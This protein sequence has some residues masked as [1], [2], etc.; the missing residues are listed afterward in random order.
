MGYVHKTKAG[1]YQVDY[2]DPTGRKKSKTFRTAKAASAFLAETEAAKN[3]GSY[4]DPHAGKLR[5]GEFAERWA[6]SQDL[7]ARA[8]E[9]TRSLLRTHVLPRWEAWPLMKIEHLA[10]QEWAKRLGRTLS[11]ATVRKAYGVMSR[12]M[13]AAVRSRLLAVNPCEGVRVTGESAGAATAITREV[14]LNKLLPATPTSHRALVAT[15]GGTGLRWGELA[16]LPWGSVDLDAATLR[17]RQVAVETSEEITIKPS[18]KT[19]AGVRTIPLPAFVVTELR[20]LLDDRPSPSPTELVFSTASGTAFRR[21]NF[22]RQVWRPTLVRAGLLGRVVERG[23][24]RFIACWPDAEGVE[25][26]VEFHTER[27]A[28]AHVAKN[29][30]GG[31][32]FHDLRHSYATWLVLDGLPVN[33][34]QRIMGHQKAT[35]TLNLYT[36]APT[37][38]DRRV[39]DTFGPAAEETPSLDQV[40]SDASNDKI[41]DD[42]PDQGNESGA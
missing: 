38:Y 23:E 21:S 28:I 15:A 40:D 34:V 8:G 14:F 24:H 25:W 17:V 20:R 33:V 10:V 4:V 27:E 30:A 22:R 29:A 7:G 37:D 12:I 5:F 18:P 3:R 1:S 35:T 11:P 42:P 16:G 32:R 31:L 36:H 2:R 13:A 39:R 19:R 26:E 6:T 41:T 9:R